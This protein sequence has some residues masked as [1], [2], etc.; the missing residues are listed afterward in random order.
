MNNNA[1]NS[2]AAN[3]TNDDLVVQ[4]V[5]LAMKALTVKPRR[6]VGKS[7][8]PSAAAVGNGKAAA[9]RRSGRTARGKQQY[10]SDSEQDDDDDGEEYE[11]EK[12]NLRA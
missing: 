8:Q 4:D 2:T 12:E 6:N 10:S 3:G 5:Q 1:A 11:K 7:K 9:A